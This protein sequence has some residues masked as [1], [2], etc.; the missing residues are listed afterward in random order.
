MAGRVDIRK[1]RV[2]LVCGRAHGVQVLR[3]T[4]GML[5]LKAVSVMPTA[6]SALDTLKV[7]PFTAVFCDGA[8]EDVDGMP[9]TLAA[10]RL[11]GM[12]NPMVPIFTLASFPS[13][14]DVERARDQGVTDVLA[15]P[16]SAA[17]IV[18][19]L[20]TALA[21]PRPFIAASDFFGPDRRT[22]QSANF[23]AADRRVRQPK[24]LTYP[25]PP[26]TIQ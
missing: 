16:V 22:R 4:F 14:A 26:S 17:V 11:P 9:F 3:T 1:A 13:R 10:R 18:R 24:K 21:H 6:A 19:K 12:L 15:Q 25:V 2:L 5:N 7:H 20:R 8:I 23:S